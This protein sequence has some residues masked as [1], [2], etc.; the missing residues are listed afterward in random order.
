LHA[1]IPVINFKSSAFMD[2]RKFLQTSSLASGAFFLPS[3]LKA[4]ERRPLPAGNKNLV[5]IQ[6]SGGNDGLNTLVP[7]ENDI[8][9]NKRKSLALPKEGLIRLNDQ[10][11]MNPALQAL[12]EVYDQGWMGVLNSVGYPN[13]DRSHFRSMDI[14]HSASNANEFLNTGWIGRY[15]DSNCGACNKPYQAIEADDTL[16]LAMKGE[17]RKGLAIRDAGNFYKA[18]REP[19][20]NTLAQD[21][22][23]DML[24]EDNLGYLYKTMIETC[25]S[26]DYINNAIRTFDNKAEYPNTAFSKQLKMISRFIQSGLETKVYYVSLTGFDTHV[27]QK[28][29][30]DRLLKEWAEGVQTF[31]K[32]LRQGG[33]L[34]DTLV[35]TFSEF[36][37]RVEQNAS[38]G[39]DHGTANNVFLFGGK[40]NKKGI[41]NDAP[42]LENLDNGDLKYQ[43]DF[44]SVYATI[45]SKWLEVDDEAILNRKFPVMDF[46]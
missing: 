8:Y 38:N 46:V 44:R 10:L 25:S 17:N 37:R 26:A 29:T 28:G 35:M 4:F 18:T 20:F 34:D 36:G 13:P 30:Q 23:P 45:V 31:L 12:K 22:N 16:S 32:D 19:F 27:G 40:L 5:I 21:A 42:D 3:F 1:L 9:Y 7:F 6:L 33:K 39:T 2:R 24:N 11:G 15:L 14:W 43:V 41:L